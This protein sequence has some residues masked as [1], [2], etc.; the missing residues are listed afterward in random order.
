MGDTIDQI[1]KEIFGKQYSVIKA[2]VEFK[3]KLDEELKASKTSVS[4]SN[5]IDAI[6]SVNSTT[7]I[8]MECILP[9]AEMDHFE[10]K[11]IPLL[12]NR[13]EFVN[14]DAV[15][16][17]VGYLGHLKT[18]QH[19]SLC[20]SMLRNVKKNVYHSEIA[21]STGI[22][23]ITQW[24]QKA[25]VE[26]DFSFIRHVLCW[27]AELPL[28][29]LMSISPDRVAT[30][31]SVLETV[32][33]NCSTV[34]ASVRGTT[35]KDAVALRLSNP[36]KIPTSSINV[37][38]QE[39]TSLES[40]L[41]N[42]VL[43]PRDKTEDG[44][45]RPAS[46]TKSTPSPAV[47]KKK[48]R[49]ESD[50]RGD[51]APKAVTPAVST[52]ATTAL[53]QTPLQAAPRVAHTPQ[54][55]PA[56]LST[57]LT[58]V[59][60]SQSS[61]SSVPSKNARRPSSKPAD[62]SV[63]ARLLGTAAPPQSTPSSTSTSSA[64]ERSVSVTPTTAS[65]SSEAVPEDKTVA[66]ANSVSVPMSDTAASEAETPPANDLVPVLPEFVSFGSV[67][68][69]ER[70]PRQTKI[71]WA[72]ES[73][74]KLCEFQE[75]Q[76][77]LEDEKAVHVGESSTEEGEGGSGDSSEAYE[78]TGPVEHPASN[79]SSRGYAAMRR[80]EHQLERQM[81]SQVHAAQ[82]P[83]LA[84]SWQR[85]PMSAPVY[86]ETGVVAP[87]RVCGKESRL[88]TQRLQLRA[89]AVYNSSDRPIPADPLAPSAPVLPSTRRLATIAWESPEEIEQAA[90][91]ADKVT[92][93]QSDAES[94]LD[95]LPPFVQALT[96]LQLATLVEL[97][98]KEEYAYV[99]EDP[100]GPDFLALVESIAPGASSSYPMTFE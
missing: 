64:P 76:A 32:I 25:A 81:I 17:F 24:L 27:L 37:F 89:E 90:L 68:R 39:A 33:K 42:V 4:K 53:P 9:I 28:T 22:K 69:N 36:F 15:K 18:R 77:G 94:L 30:V 80:E 54:S 79:R 3:H 75:F 61:A 14:I 23:I 31:V 20:I 91:A 7:A 45:K 86:H 73:G 40:Y 70:M 16:T 95:L 38:L 12:N 60:S 26:R 19:K 48:P 41:K 98:S 55:V 67:A 50:S 74:A 59:D 13:G 49:V 46:A 2:Q 96:P 35:T 92:G 72:D 47:A 63:L 6:E 85:P 62:S 100:Y 88:Q 78:D 51:R 93:S 82:R 43:R 1:V 5:S 56:V 34:V 83:A 66:Y 99:M 52:T 87:D 71:R 57:P 10:S 11:L 65:V 29:S 44:K 8:P 84:G 58:S 97:L 21:R